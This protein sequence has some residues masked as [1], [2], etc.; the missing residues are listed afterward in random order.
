MDKQAVLSRQAPKPGGTYSQAI[1]V[2]TLVFLSGQLPIDPHSNQLVTS[3]TQEMYRQCFKNLA[4][5]CLAAGGSLD[6]IV[7]LNVY[8]VDA[9]YAAPLDEVMP[10]F[11]TQP[12]PARTRMTVRQ[13]SKDAAVELD[14]IMAL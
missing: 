7:K 1:R 11:F 14:G 10:E 6:R 8:F 5:V 3:S 2:D 9:K 13:L 4:A 12:Y